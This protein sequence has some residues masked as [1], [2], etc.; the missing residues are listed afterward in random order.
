MSLAINCRTTGMMPVEL[1]V[2][3]DVKARHVIDPKDFTMHNEWSLRRELHLSLREVGEEDRL[4]PTVD[5][6]AIVERRPL[7]Y[8]VNIALPMALFAAM[9]NFQFTLPRS[10]TPDRFN[11]CFS[12]LLAFSRL[13]SPSLAFSRLLSPSLTCS[14]LLSP[15]LTFSHARV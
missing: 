1:L 13:L 10:A 3:P 5:C 7:F 8:I 2:A 15:S 9:S 12:L 14:H 6:I 4:F 11:V